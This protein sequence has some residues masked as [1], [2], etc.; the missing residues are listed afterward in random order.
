MMKRKPLIV[1]MTDAQVLAWAKAFASADGVNSARVI[2]S[3]AAD[4]L[5]HRNTSSS[6]EALNELEAFLK[7]RYPQGR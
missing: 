4:A 2:V 7:E 5:K 3:L 1:E 6:L